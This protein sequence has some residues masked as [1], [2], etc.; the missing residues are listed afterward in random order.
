MAERS[1]CGVP[2]QSVGGCG[3]RHHMPD[4]NTRIDSLKEGILAIG[5]S[6]LDLR[7]KAVGQE[8]RFDQIDAHLDQIDSRLDQIDSRLDGHDV[9]FD[10]HDVRFDH[11][12]AQLAEIL[13]RLPRRSSEG[14]A[15]N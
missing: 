3:Y 7:A 14:D 10:G 5:D 2:G 15:L 12:D 6:V 9:R 8:R 1:T 4:A 13:A 11:V